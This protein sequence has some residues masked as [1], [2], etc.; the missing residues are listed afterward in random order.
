[1]EAEGYGGR[2]GGSWAYSG[3]P[4]EA[5]LR[6]E[7][8]TTDGTNP[9][10]RARGSQV[11]RAW[12]LKGS[13][14]GSGRGGVGDIFR[15]P[16]SSLG[17]LQKG[18]CFCLKGG[19]HRGSGRRWVACSTAGLIP[20]AL[21]GVQGAAFVCLPIPGVLDLLSY[22][23]HLVSFLLSPLAGTVEM[24]SLGDWQCPPHSKARNA[25]ASSSSLAD[26]PSTRQIG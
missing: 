11:S 17:S 21:L 2:G 13:V 15:C 26:P 3:D 23:P 7:N 10:C 9:P 19:G 5:K 22:L 4:L 18:G 6:W 24:F 16:S 1:M 14:A 8:K 12:P 20:D 25:K